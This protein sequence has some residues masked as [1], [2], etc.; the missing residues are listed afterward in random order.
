ML[1]RFGRRVVRSG[2]RVMF[3][4]MMLGRPVMFRSTVV[5]GGSVM[6]GFVSGLGYRFVSRLRQRLMRC[7]GKGRFT[8]VALVL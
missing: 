6:L 2:G 5:L 4:G 8:R 3:G 1:G 7:L